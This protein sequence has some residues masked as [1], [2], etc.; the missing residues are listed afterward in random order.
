MDVLPFGAQGFYQVV[1]DFIGALERFWGWKPLLRNPRSKNRNAVI[2]HKTEA[3]NCK[4]GSGSW[5]SSLKLMDFL[6]ALRVVQGAVGTNLYGLGCPF[7]CSSPSV[8]LLLLC[9][10]IGLVLGS[11]GTIFLAFRLG[12]WTLP[13]PQSSAP[14]SVSGLGRLQ[15]YSHAKRA[16]EPHSGKHSCWALWG[17]RV[18]T[19]A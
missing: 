16:W 13:C 3:C 6:G 12:F 15:A 18:R 9:V 7:Y 2:S 17:H 4:H 5:P 1:Q 19:P 11:A 8:P 10:V 14:P